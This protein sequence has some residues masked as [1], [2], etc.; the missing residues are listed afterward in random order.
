MGLGFRVPNPRPFTLSFPGLKS[1]HR[2][3]GRLAFCHGAL[4]PMGLI[5]M[6]TFTRTVLR[7]WGL[8]GLGLRC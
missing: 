2:F 4:K 8:G 7:V 3:L 1:S 6:G 5:H